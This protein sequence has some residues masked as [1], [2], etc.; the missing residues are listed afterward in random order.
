MGMI[1]RL[2]P[3]TSAR[4]GLVVLAAAVLLSVAAGAL[5]Y[6][7][8]EI[9]TYR[10][11]DPAQFQPGEPNREAVAAAQS[12]SEFPLVWLGEEFEGFKLTDVLRREGPT[13]NKVYL[14]Y[15][16]CEPEPGESE[17]SCVR[18]LSIVVNTAGFV[19]PPNQVEERVAG[20]LTARRGV[21]ARMLSGSMVLWT[22]G[23]VITIHANSEH[24]EKAIENLETVNHGARGEEAIGKGESLAP[25]AARQ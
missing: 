11:A 16:E 20:P 7:N 12:F 13:Y 5:V 15:G 9:N 22:G 18:P 24:M 10:R 25:L 8:N 17:P 21:P 14:V 2:R 4:I 23:V 6:A 1:N 19:P 3:L